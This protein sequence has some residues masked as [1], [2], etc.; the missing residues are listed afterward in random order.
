MSRPNHQEGIGHEPHFQQPPAEPE[1]TENIA[2]DTLAQ[3]KAAADFDRETALH[4]VY[5][6]PVIFPSDAQAPPVIDRDW[7]CAGC[8][9]NLRGLTVGVPCPECGHIN[10]DR[11]TATDQASYASWLL[12]SRATTSGIKSAWVFL[13]ALLAGGPWAICGAIISSIGPLAMVAFGP[14]AEEVM[15]VSVVAL[16]VEVRPYLFK[17][18]GQIVAAAITGAFVFAAIENVMYMHFLQQPTPMLVAWRWTVCVGLHTGCTA[19]ASLG[20]SK[21]WRRTMHE[22]RQPQLGVALPWLVLAMVL[23][24]GYN[25]VVAV[26]ALAGY[27]F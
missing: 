4:S 16:V 26:L 20:I 15:K 6:E 19:I 1:E 3:E 9:Y 11:P 14:V 10:F 22:L 25:A 18:T 21:V 23:H 7:T 5:N 17:S 2:R 13:L 8:G 12:R 27:E 24:G